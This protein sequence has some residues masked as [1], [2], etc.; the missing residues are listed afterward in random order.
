M[1]EYTNPPTL[2]VPKGYTH[3]VRSTGRTTI[4]VAGQVSY[5]STGAVVGVGDLRR[6]TEQ[7]YANVRTALEAAGAT[8]ADMVKTTILIRDMTPEKVATI[9]EV[10]ARVLAGHPPPASTLIAVPTLIHP[11]LL[12]EIEATAIVD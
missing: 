4:T 12:L 5:D 8:L 3:V 9:R 11:D 2:A 7:V 1:N 10:R 6:Q